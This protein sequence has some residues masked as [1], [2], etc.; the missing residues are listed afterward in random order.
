MSAYGLSATDPKTGGRIRGWKGPTDTRVML[1]DAP[2]YGFRSQTDWGA[3]IIKYLKWRKQLRRVFVLLDAQVG[4][5]K[6][7]REILVLLRKYG[8]SHQLI[9]TKADKIGGPQKRRGV[10][11]QNLREMR[12]VSQT[13][14][15]K[16]TLAALGEILVTGSLGDGKGN[17]RIKSGQFEGL[18]EVRW[19]VLRAAGLEEYAVASFGKTEEAK[20]YGDAPVQSI[21][22][23]VSTLTEGAVDG[24][25]DGAVDEQVASKVDEVEQQAWAPA[26]G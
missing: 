8:I 10:L 17:D 6:Q 12:E 4:L 20:G 21:M 25:V 15:G 13:R 22:T 9:A 11:D 23:P 2:G 18:D 5:K 3:E 7:D 1:L 26:F 19:S 14:T 24:V 16:G